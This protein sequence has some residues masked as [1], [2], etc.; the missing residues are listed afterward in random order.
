MENALI[1]GATQGIGRSVAVAFAKQGI[2]MA[3]CSR[4]V[5]DLAALKQELLAINP[6]IQVF[7]L[8]VDCS[9]KDELLNYARQAQQQLG[10]IKV[11]V[12]NVGMFQPSSILDDADDAFTTNFNTNLMPAYELYRFFGKSMMDERAGHFFNICSI[13][14]KEPVV[15]AG[16]YSVT[17]AA[18]Y[19]LTHIMKL[20]MQAYSIK[21]TAVLPGSTLTGSWA[22]TEVHPD[23]FVMPDDI[24]AAIL[25]AYNMS[26]GAN[27]DEI[28]IKPVL[29]QL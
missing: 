20:E 18:L 19:S 17:K 5:K 8:A 22:G 15:N 25:N 14:A 21:V 2:S 12:N 26:K 29:G 27:V 3:I 7:A 11:V 9:R 10:F 1:T 13:A 16:I 6:N 24:A 4:N 28:I 23:R